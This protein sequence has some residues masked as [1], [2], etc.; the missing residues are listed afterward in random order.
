MNDSADERSTQD[1]SPDSIHVKPV[2]KQS[3]RKVI[4][5]IVLCACTVLIL[6]TGP[7][8]GFGWQVVLSCLL[9]FFLFWL[10]T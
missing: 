3:I 5:F 4:A 1:P 6:F 2:I 7:E 8:L 9:L 10:V